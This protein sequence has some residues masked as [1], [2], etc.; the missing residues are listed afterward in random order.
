MANGFL[1]KVPELP[2]VN[3]SGLLHGYSLPLKLSNVILKGSFF[4][5]YHVPKHMM[6]YTHRYTASSYL[7]LRNLMIKI[8]DLQKRE[9]A[10]AS[11]YSRRRNVLSVTNTPFYA[12]NVARTDD[13]LRLY[14][15]Y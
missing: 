2:K 9:M 8:N 4:L 11:R 15:T 14:D 1:L 6:H 5:L 10:L 13:K 12:K 7:R 3:Y